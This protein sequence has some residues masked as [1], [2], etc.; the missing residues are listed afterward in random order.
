MAEDQR[1]LASLG[2]PGN[3]RGGGGGGGDKMGCGAPAAANP[4][5]G[6]YKLEVE[7]VSLNGFGVDTG[8]VGF[9]RGGGG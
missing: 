2:A 8:G 4:A 9:G 1:L 6:L 7:L 5:Y 3:G